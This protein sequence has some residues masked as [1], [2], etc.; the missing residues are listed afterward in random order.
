V[1]VCTE[2]SIIQNELVFGG[3][4]IDTNSLLARVAYEYGR[5]IKEINYNGNVT[6][7]KE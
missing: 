2:L 6:N 7:N 5:G 3:L 1:L 4:T